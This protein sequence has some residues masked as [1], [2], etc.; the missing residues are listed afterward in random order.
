[1]SK[2]IHTFH[3]LGG[4]DDCPICSPP[5]QPKGSSCKHPN[6]NL[7]GGECSLCGEQVYKPDQRPPQTA[8]PKTLLECGLPVSS[9]E[10]ATSARE[11]TLEFGYEGKLLWPPNQASH[12]VINS[13]HVIEKSA[14]DSVVKERDEAVRA[15]AD[16]E[17]EA[18][19]INEM[20]ALRD[21][22]LAELE[23]SRSNN[24]KCL[25]KLIDKINDATKIELEL[26][27]VKV[28]RDGALKL[29]LSW[30]QQDRIAE[31]ERE[32]DEWKQRACNA[33]IKQ[34]T[35]GE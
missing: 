16:Y 7:L 23:A 32:R 15:R 3:R 5:D 4:K 22:A 28:E 17:H 29:V 10:R 11:F 18:E 31:L 33:E 27:A 1:M 24:Q 8:N 2:C 20:R 35:D 19:T 6:H 13:V 25:G 30:D 9:P 14:Y 21:S 26:E 12:K 34:V